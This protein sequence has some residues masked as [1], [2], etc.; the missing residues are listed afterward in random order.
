MDVKMSEY[1]EDLLTGLDDT[2]F[3][4]KSKIRSN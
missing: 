1:A 4:E 3:K 2:N